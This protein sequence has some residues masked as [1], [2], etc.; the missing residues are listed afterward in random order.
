[1]NLEI[2]LENLRYNV[3]SIKS[4]TFDAKIIAVVKANAY[5]HGAVKIAQTLRREVYAFAVANE[6]EARELVSA[7]ITEPIFVLGGII[8]DSQYPVNVIP[9]VSNKSGIKRATG[10]CKSVAIAVN[11]GMNRYGC[12]PKGLK[13]LANTANDYGLIVR[14]VFTHV[15][16]ETDKE[17]SFSQLS[18]FTGVTDSLKIESS[19]A[20]TCALNLGKPFCADCVRAGI[21]LYGYGSADLK[22]IASAFAP[23]VSVRAVKKDERIGY[24]KYFA[25]RNMKIAVVAAGYADGLMRRR[26]DL[27]AAINGIKCR[28]IGQICMDA[29]FFDVSDIDCRAGDYAYFIGNGASMRDICATYDTIPY[30]ILTAFDRRSTKIYV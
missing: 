23:I 16:D 24:G 2:S 12:D 20:A 13:S 18:A 17:A 5:G 7:G 1:M 4:R 10:K 19:V 3:R 9:S 25:D 27:F 8:S 30:E 11:T 15:A 6:R 22:P 21:G 26:R 28:A 14:H 29:S